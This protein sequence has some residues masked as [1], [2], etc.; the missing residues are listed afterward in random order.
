MKRFVSLALAFILAV[1]VATPVFASEPRVDEE[2]MPEYIEDYFTLHVHGRPSAPITRRFIFAE[3]IVIA[4]LHEAAYALSAT[5]VWDDANNVVHWTPEGGRVIAISFVEPEGFVEDGVVWVPENFVWEVFFLT[6]DQGFGHVVRDD[7]PLAAPVVRITDH[8]EMATAFIQVM[9]DTLYNRVPFSYRE[10][11]A[12][13]WIRDQ[14]LEMG[15]DEDAV[16][17]Q[18][19]SVDDLVNLSGFWGGNLWLYEHF[20]AFYPELRVD[21]EGAIDAMVEAMIEQENEWIAQMAES[22]EMTFEEARVFVAENAGMSVDFLDKFIEAMARESAPWQLGMAD[23]FG[24]LD[25][26]MQF[27]PYSQNV[28]LTVPGQSERTIIVTAHY[29]SVMVPGASDNASGTALLLE[30]AYRLRDVDNYFTVI[31]IFMGAEEVGIYGAFYYVDSLTLAERNNIVLNINADVLFE[32]PYFFFG[33][34]IRDD[35]WWLTENDVSNMV[36]H[37]AEHVNATYGTVLINAPSLAEMPSDQQAF[38]QAGHT[39]T[40]L[41]GLARSDSEDYA[42]FWGFGV[43]DMYPGFRASVVHTENDCYHFINATWPTKIGDAM[44]TFSLFLDYLLVADFDYSNLPEAGLINNIIELPEADLTDHLL[45]GTWSWDEDA[46]WTFVFNPD[47]TGTR[48]RAGS[49]VGFTWS[50]DDFEL[51]IQA[52]GSNITE[53]WS[54]W[55][56]D[57]DM[58]IMGL[59][60]S[61]FTYVR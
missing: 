45:I 55:M 13:N 10:L 23:V 30:S 39:V 19:F 4:N 41:V 53:V 57:D 18:T 54:L 34:G 49:Q 7:I 47:G 32:G 12:A 33:A 9:N 38:L 6:R 37:V 59:L 60:W 52:E 1:L 3:G 14:L 20:N 2:D 17:L 29:C 48:G 21:R 15:Y 28:I 51:F 25:L 8:G 50:A 61:S 35:G 5:A 22:M 44:W 11:E 58:L 31:Y 43:W 42:D 24:L 36:V 27:R 46:T 26:D 40:A 16:V 56:L